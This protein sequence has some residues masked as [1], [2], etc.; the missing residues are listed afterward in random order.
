MKKNIVYIV[1]GLEGFPPRVIGA[2]EAARL[3]G[4]TAQHVR[5]VALGERA[6]TAEFNR[7]V[8]VKEIVNNG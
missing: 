3:L 2:Q 8:T 5:R 4:V 1:T 6:R 7:L